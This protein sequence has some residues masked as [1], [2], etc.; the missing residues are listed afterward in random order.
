RGQGHRDRA[1]DAPVGPGDD[2]DRVAHRAFPASR[3]ADRMR[4]G[5]IGSS[6][7]RT[8]SGARASLT[9]AL[10]A[11]GA[12]IRPPSPPPLTPGGVY[13]DGVATCPIASSGTS[14]ADGI[15]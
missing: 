10:I 9:A 14:I 3:R 11:A 13:G 2:N 4:S 6:V 1:P 15:R 7:M 5:V 12:I 8:P